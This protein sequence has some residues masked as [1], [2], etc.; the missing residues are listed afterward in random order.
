MAKLSNSLFQSLIGRA[1]IDSHIRR[2]A[3]RK[4][5]LFFQELLEKHGITD[6]KEEDIE[7]LSFDLI[8]ELCLE[9]YSELGS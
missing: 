3:G 1:F 4:V 9:D 5:K 6:I 7:E 2:I 8:D